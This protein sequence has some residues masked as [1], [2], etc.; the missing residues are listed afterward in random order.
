MNTVIIVTNT[1]VMQA[2]VPKERNTIR[3]I[4]MTTPA[5]IRAA[6]ILEREMVTIV[7]NTPV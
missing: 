7:M 3:I 5:T 2:A 4:A 6:T 1:S